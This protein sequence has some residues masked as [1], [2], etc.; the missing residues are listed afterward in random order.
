MIT[1]YEIKV[2][3]FYSTT[4]ENNRNELGTALKKRN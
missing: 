2:A 3:K 4:E 1:I